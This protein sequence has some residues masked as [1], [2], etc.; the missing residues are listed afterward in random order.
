MGL[1]F[2]SF[3]KECFE[4]MRH[5]FVWYWKYVGQIFFK[6]WQKWWSSITLFLKPYCKKSSAIKKNLHS[7]DKLWHSVWVVI[8]TLHT[9]ECRPCFAKRVHH[10][11]QIS[12]RQKI[13]ITSSSVYLEDDS[14]LFL[15]KYEESLPR[16][17]Y[18]FLG[19]PPVL[20]NND[21]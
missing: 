19:V 18:L 2:F 21:V 6:F 9:Q 15:T 14:K 13:L 5:E 17:T 7:H 11:G 10:T 16:T 20:R 12:Y 3:L 1:L 4:W 8:W